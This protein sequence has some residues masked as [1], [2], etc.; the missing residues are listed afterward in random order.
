MLV[1]ATAVLN[2]TSGL[3]DYFYTINDVVVVC[4]FCALVPLWTFIFIK[5]LKEI[6]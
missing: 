5:I 4:F 3:V 2:S 1:E 6:C